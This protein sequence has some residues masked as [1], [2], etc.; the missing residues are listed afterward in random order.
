MIEQRVACRPL[1]A[2][3]H[4]SKITTTQIHPKA[5]ALVPPL[6]RAYRAGL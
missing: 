1:R 5:T 4:P 6:A 2:G 3:F